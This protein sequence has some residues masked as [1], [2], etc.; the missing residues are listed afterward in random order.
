[1]AASR[2]LPLAATILGLAVVAMPAAADKRPV[3]V[4]LF[5][6]QGWCIRRKSSSR[7][8]RDV[9]PELTAELRTLLLL[10]LCH[11]RAM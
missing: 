10:G 7:S 1:M 4:E 3:V 2:T 9:A 5:P 11:S 8:L 6:S